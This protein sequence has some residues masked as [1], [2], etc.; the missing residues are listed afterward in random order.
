[1]PEDQQNSDM[2]FSTTNKKA[3]GET[4]I[5]ATSYDT[6]SDSEYAQS[7]KTAGKLKMKPRQFVHRILFQL[8]WARELRE[9]FRAITGVKI[10]DTN[11]TTEFDEDQLPDKVL[12]KIDNCKQHY[13]RKFEMELAE[14]RKSFKAEHN[15]IKLTSDSCN[16]KRD[17]E[18]PWKDLV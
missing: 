9:K 6:A 4:I 3:A 8:N 11:S 12:E 10:S 16:H 7:R 17:H 2:A 18:I 5:Q 13:L 1:M 15:S 14:F